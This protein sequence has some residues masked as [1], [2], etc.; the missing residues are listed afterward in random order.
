MVYRTL[1][2]LFVMTMLLC[3]TGC[4]SVQSKPVLLIEPEYS[5][6]RAGDDVTP[7]AAPIARRT[8]APVALNAGTQRGGV[9]LSSADRLP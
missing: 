1:V 6:V 5:Y 2:A 7:T 8:A 4:G 3:A 9:S